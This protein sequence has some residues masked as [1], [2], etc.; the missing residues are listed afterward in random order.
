MCHE[1]GV[2]NDRRALRR[3]AQHR[4]HVTDVNQLNQAPPHPRYE[5]HAT[6]RHAEAGQGVF[7]PW[8]VDGNRS[9]H[10]DLKSVAPPQHLHLR[11]QLAATVVARRPRRVLHLTRP[12]Q[13]PRSRRRLA[14]AEH[15]PHPPSTGDTGVDQRTRAIAVGGKQRSPRATRQ[16]CTVDDRVDTGDRFCKLVITQIRLDQLDRL[17]LQPA[18]PACRAHQTAHAIPRFQQGIDHVASHE[19]AAARH[20]RVSRLTC[21]LWTCLMFDGSAPTALWR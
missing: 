9:Q 8:A 10:H 15:E 1:I 13:R 14:A 20:Q 2:P 7:V 5:E 17:A 4:G 3:P 18:Q 6:S 21:H 16:P 12:L 11:R 19:A